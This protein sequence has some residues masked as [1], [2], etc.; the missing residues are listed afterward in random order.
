[1]NSHGKLMEKTIKNENVFPCNF[2]KLIRNFCTTWSIF[3]VI[4][5]QDDISKVQHI[6]WTYMTELGMERCFVKPTKEK[7]L[8]AGVQTAYLSILINYFDVET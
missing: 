4:Y 5:L 8:V 6:V 3:I 2:M 1:M 7:S